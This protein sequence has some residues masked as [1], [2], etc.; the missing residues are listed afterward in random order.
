MIVAKTKN[1]IAKILIKL[2]GLNPRSLKKEM[3]YY[4]EIDSPSSQLDLEKKD[5]GVWAQ[6][7]NLE[8]H[9]KNRQAQIRYELF[10][11]GFLYYFEKHVKE[12]GNVDRTIYFD[13]GKINK[14]A[15]LTIFLKPFY[16]IPL[17][18]KQT[19]TN[20]DINRNGNGKYSGSV[21][22]QEEFNV[23]STTP[24]GKM[25]NTA[26]APP[27]ATGTDPEPPPPPPPPPKE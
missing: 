2:K 5:F 27:P 23:L 24:G 17:K 8:K 20:S 7:E 1:E 15:A 6:F 16:G 19:K 26:I 3:S 11:G 9:Y 21:N 12:S 18:T 13:W 22:K 25:Q 4:V 10:V 14:K